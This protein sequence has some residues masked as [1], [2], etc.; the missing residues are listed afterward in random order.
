MDGTETQ[1][2]S[3]P[4]VSWELWFKVTAPTKFT[5]SGKY[6]PCDS[7]FISMAEIRHTLDIGVLAAQK[8]AN[9][10]GIKFTVNGQSRPAD[11]KKLLGA[12]L[13]Y[14]VGGIGENTTG[15]QVNGKP[16]KSSRLAELIAQWKAAH[17]PVVTP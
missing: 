8:L 4:A 7:E 16:L 12:T 3:K 5:D 2:T 15:V 9:T 1:G 11:D 10:G 14:N 6:V 13:G 17:A